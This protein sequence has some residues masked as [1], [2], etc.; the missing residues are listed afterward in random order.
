[1]REY[2]QERAICHVSSFDARV[3][4]SIAYTDPEVAWVGLTEDRASAEEV[5]RDETGRIHTG[6]IGPAIVHH[7]AGYRKL[8]YFGNTTVNNQ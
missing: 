1:M 8:R 3:I 5:V 4:P 7:F 2:S 6:E